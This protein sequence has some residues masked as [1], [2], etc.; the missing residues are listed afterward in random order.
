M[1][2]EMAK[3][4]KIQVNQVP[5][6]S[7]PER[8]VALLYSDYETRLDLDSFVKAMDLVEDE[9][10]ASLFLVMKPGDKRDRWLE[11]HVGTEL[12]SLNTE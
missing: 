10:K 6:R 3:R 1:T 2:E 5:S 11:L 4:R 8:A 7:K 12:R 9:S